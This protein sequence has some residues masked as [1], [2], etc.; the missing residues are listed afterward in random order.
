MIRIDDFE[1]VVFFTGAG[2]S[3]ESGIPTY[4][5]AGGIWNEY[6]YED[7]ACQRAFESDPEK[8]W[9]FHDRR[10]EAVAACE[11]NEGH[12]IIA[13]MP[14]AF[15]VT[16]NIDGLHQRAGSRKILELHGSLWRL[17][18]QQ[19]GTSVENTDVP[20][21]PR[22]CPCGTY[23]RPGIVWFEDMLDPAVVRQAEEAV[24]N[25][26]LLVSV[27][28]SGVVYP[29]AGLPRL[30][31]AA[32]RVEVNPEET[33]VSGWYDVRLRGNASKMLRQLVG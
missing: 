5:G 2:L 8:V 22:T 20:L 11:P 29:A 1:R 15:V 26:D 33:P 18:C 13:S 24:R 4:R 9:D 28:T 6:N 30:A 27:G 19:C 10:R 12:E 25:C 31:A 16:Q 7:Y 23:W 17:R 3:A 32:T 14:D 21:E